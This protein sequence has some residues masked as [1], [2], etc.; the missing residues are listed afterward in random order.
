MDRVSSRRQSA[1]HYFLTV[2]SF[3]VVLF[4]IL[5][6]TTPASI[7]R[8]WSLVVPVAG[9]VTCVAWAALI[10]SYRQLNTGKFK[11]IHELETVLPA[12]LFDAEW[13]VLE[14]GKGKA[15]RPFTH[16]EVW[17][18]WVFVTLYVA[19][20]MLGAIRFFMP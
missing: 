16:L 7:H 19:L 2:N 5:A 11:I 15:Y 3:F 12:A 18:P 20:L 9:I 13:Q 8:A 17:I 4:G 1:N 14:E 6:Q 10:N